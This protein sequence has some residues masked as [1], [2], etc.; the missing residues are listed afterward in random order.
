MTAQT[1]TSL[2]PPNRDPFVGSW[3][4]NATKSRPK[5]KDASYVRTIARDGDELVF[6]TRSP[7]VPGG[8]HENHYRILCDG[9]PHRVPCG[10]CSCITSCIYKAENLVEGETESTDGKLYWTREVSADYQ[11]MTILGYKDKAKTKLKA[12][13]VLDRTN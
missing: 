4:V 5:P 7:Q 2:P 3:Q 11:E 12:T 6:T 9:L 10:Q 1:R 13:W 8:V